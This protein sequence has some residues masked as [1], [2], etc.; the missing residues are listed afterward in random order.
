ML[1]QS[2]I[3]KRLEFHQA[4]VVNSHVVYTSGKHGS[5][6][7]NKDAIYPHTE[8]TSQLCRQIAETWKST[9]IDAV[10][11]PALGGIILSQWIAF[12]L[13]EM[14]KKDILGIYAEK[15]G[16]SFIVKRGYDEL[17][18]EKNVL[19]VEDI[20]TTGGSIKKVV[21]VVRKIPANIVGV[22]ALCNR[23]GITEKDIG[24][25]PRLTSLF[26]VDLQAWE[27]QD[28]KLCK[29]NVPINVKVGKGKEF[30]EKRK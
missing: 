13:S 3:L 10:L 28:C 16:D 12:H 26:S 6:Y 8:L 17:V 9:P 23:G 11:A 24:G 20:L 5:A 22:A 14:H 4:L 15:D 7:V 30:L 27:L 29:E 2:E 18:R 25:V 19:L 1:S 21:E